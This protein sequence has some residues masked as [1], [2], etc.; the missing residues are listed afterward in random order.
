MRAVSFARQGG[1]E[2]LEL[3]QAAR[4]EPGPGQVLIRVAYAGVNYAEVMY[5]RGDFKV[6]TPFTPG[7]EVSGHVE[8]V[9]QDV[10]GLE[11]GQS[12]AALTLPG[13]GYADFAVARAVLTFPL[14]T[15]H[16]QVPLRVA[17]GFPCIAPTAYGLVHAVGR[18]ERGEGVL[19][20]AAAGGVGTVAAQLARELGAGRIVGVVG[21]AGKVPYA[22]T[23]DYDR[24]MTA[25][26]FPDGLA[27][28]FGTL[29]PDVVL[30]SVGGAARRTNLEL[31]APLGR[32]VV[33]GSAGAKEDV[34]VSANQLWYSSK[35][36]VGYSIG[37]LAGARPDLLRKHA[38]EALDLVAA[39]RI[40]I[41]VTDV[42]PLA[43][44]GEAH[45]RL[46]GRAT[47]GKTVLEVAA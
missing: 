10:T 29:G 14:D 5:R 1:P 40:R 8:A 20:H 15:R 27:G 43:E 33:Y 41:D 11:P 24:V 9:G 34:P 26:E 19:I 13:G 12:V 25:A 47:R 46:E 22:E 35:S 38:L 39:G 2:A 21:N 30:D 4:P 7:L 23:F 17:G 37:A 45:R 32:L 6:A 44:A 18:V 16:G 42:H 31:L 36:V 28:E 3:I